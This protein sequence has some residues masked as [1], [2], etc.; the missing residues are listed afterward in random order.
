MLAQS[1]S[2]ALVDVAADD[3]AVEQPQQ[4]RPGGK[5][6]KEMGE[7][8]QRPLERAP[9]SHAV[10]ELVDDQGWRIAAHNNGCLVPKHG[11]V[12]LEPRVL[13]EKE[14]GGA[15]SVSPATAQSLEVGGCSVVMVAF[16][17]E[18]TSEPKAFQ[19]GTVGEVDIA[20][21]RRCL[22]RCR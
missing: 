22:V 1:F 6:L 14:D 21:G 12:G 8:F 15:G 20:T 2:V 11:N 4:G 19:M 16:G 13:L 10:E 9:R 18:A 7:P 17:L 5:D 3:P